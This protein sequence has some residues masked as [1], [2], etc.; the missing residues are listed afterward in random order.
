MA[1]KSVILRSLRA[2]LLWWLTMMM[3]FQ[4][5]FV[6]RHVHFN[7]LNVGQYLSS[8]NKV[9]EMWTLY[10]SGFFSTDF[11]STPTNGFAVFL[12]LGKKFRRKIL[13]FRRII[14]R[15]YSKKLNFLHYICPKSPDFR[16]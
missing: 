12:S 4:L 2:F 9:Q 13:E 7:Y 5:P 15:F 3:S 6:H 8:D 16:V 10:K 11:L 14:L 1:R